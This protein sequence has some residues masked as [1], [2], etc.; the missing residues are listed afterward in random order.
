[1]MGVKIAELRDKRATVQ[2]GGGKDRIE[3]QHAAGKLTARERIEGLVDRNSFQEIGLFARHRATYLGMAE[4][5]MPADGVVT[6]CATIDGR[7][8]H[9][10]S[11]DSPSPAAR[12]GKS[13]ATKL[14]T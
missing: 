12:P 3:K 10:A 13:T 14:R 8:V 4:K 1:M 5:E 9:L 2:L 7:L 6:G 11:Q